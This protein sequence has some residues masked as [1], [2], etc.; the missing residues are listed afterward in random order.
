LYNSAHGRLFAGGNIPGS[1]TE[2]QAS[3]ECNKY[4]AHFGLDLAQD[5]IEADE[6][7]N[8]KSGAQNADPDAL[9]LPL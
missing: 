7:A 9:N 2:F 4:C 6:A 3:H 1:F 5:I 8:I